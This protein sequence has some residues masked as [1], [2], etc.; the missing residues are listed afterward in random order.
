MPK[1]VTIERTGPIRAISTAA[2]KEKM[3]YAAKKAKA[4]AWAWKLVSVKMPRTDAT[5]GS[6]SEVMKPQA[7]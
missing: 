1:A 7:K 5:S 3:P 2:G 4:L 6:I